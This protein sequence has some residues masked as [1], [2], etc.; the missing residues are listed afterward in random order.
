[1]GKRLSNIVLIL[2]FLT[3]L[4]LLLYPAVS[5]YWNSTRQSRAIVE[6][7]RQA[8]D[9]DRALYDRMWADAQAYNQALSE[10]ENRYVLSDEERAEYESLLRIPGSTVL[11][12]IEIP[13]IRCA[14][15]ICHG[16]DSSVLRNAVGHL[17][18]T[19]LPVGG[20]GSHCVLS[21]HR[22]LPGAKLFTDL[23]QLTVGDEFT[24]RV[25]DETLTY[26]VDQILVVLPGELDALEIDPDR[27]YCTLVTCTPYGINSH[28]LLVR[29][30][31][32]ENRANAG[33]EPITTHPAEVDSISAAPLAAVPVLLLFAGF[34]LP[35]QRGKSGGD[36]YY[37]T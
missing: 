1:M 22:G 34:L 36:S 25:L 32:V 4:A 31:R 29:G 3:G 5:N 7:A 20:A 9:I 19:S 2:V 27:D 8:S 18:G 10:K 15:P 26:Q 30:H 28:R 12:S 35:R 23:D 6:Y 17:E 11:G 21:G 16:T 24:L 14:L 37:D 13:A 33:A